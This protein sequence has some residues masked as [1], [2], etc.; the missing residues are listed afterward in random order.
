MTPC[1][2]QSAALSAVTLQSFAS[3]VA[4]ALS[5]DQRPEEERRRSSMKV[6]VREKVRWFKRGFK[7]IF[8]RKSMRF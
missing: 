8:G 2:R 6:S 3:D 4:V 5:F 7:G 1:T